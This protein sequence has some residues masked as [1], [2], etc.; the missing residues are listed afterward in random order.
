MG[1]VDRAHVCHGYQPS[2]IRKPGLCYDSNRVR[3]PFRIPPPGSRPFDIAGFGL[4]SIDLLA[5]VAEYPASNTKQRLQRFARLPGG[6]IATAMS[7]CARL[8]W[9]ARYVGSFGDDELGALSRQSLTD[10]GVDIPRR[11]RWRA[12]RTSSP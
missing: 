9:R 10:L 4:N 2:A 8:G 5:V 12:R 3:L 11:A 1:M 6:Q 7:T